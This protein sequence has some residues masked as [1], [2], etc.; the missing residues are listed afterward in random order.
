VFAVSMDS[1]AAA[2]P[3]IGGAAAG[4]SPAAAARRGGAGSAGEGDYRPVGELEVGK[5]PDVDADACGRAVTYPAE[6]ERNG[7]AGDVRLRVSLDDRGRV[8]AAQVL[9][10]LGHGLDQAAVEALKHRCRFTPAVNRSGSP[11]AFVI[12]SYTFHFELPR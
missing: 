12:E 3:P 2:D 7:V 4:S 5:M 11:V 8:R 9:S 10:G 6:A 1:P